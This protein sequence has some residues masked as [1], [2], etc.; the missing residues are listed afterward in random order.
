MHLL[1]GYL[2]KY[3]T[4]LSYKIV[5]KLNLKTGDLTEVMKTYRSMPLD[6]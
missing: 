4:F 6:H 5:Q 3:Q 1:E 2:V